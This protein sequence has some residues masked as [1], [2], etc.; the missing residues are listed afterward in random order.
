[1]QQPVTQPTERP[2]PAEPPPRA[3]TPARPTTGRLIVSQLPAGGAVAIDGRRRSGTSFELP[4]GVRVLRMTAPGF[5]TVVDT[6]VLAAGERVT[7]PFTGQRVSPQQPPRQ[8][9]V[10]QPARRPP[11]A[12]P[13]VGVLRVLVRP[14]AIV[15]LDGVNRGRGTQLVDTLVAG[16]HTL[17]FQRPGFR[18]KDTTVTVR[19]GQLLELR[20]RMERGN[21]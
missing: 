15:V 18:T 5:E 16:A 1:M 14:W 17:R 20:I 10:R 2:P 9:V 13:Q 3:V 21:P 7:V 6:V 19:P 4:A 12:A 8:P 11:P